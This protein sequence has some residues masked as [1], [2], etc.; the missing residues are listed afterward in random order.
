MEYQKM[1]KVT[2]E[3]RER[4]DTTRAPAFIRVR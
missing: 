1:K 4:D 3:I 2:F